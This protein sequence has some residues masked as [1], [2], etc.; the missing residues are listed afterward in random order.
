MIPLVSPRDSYGE[1]RR[2][3]PGLEMFI[4]SK[5]NT[6]RG[7]FANPGLNSKPMMLMFASALKIQ[8][9]WS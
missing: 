1:T 5:K 6:Y 9:G 4:D 7:K 3:F 2:G 8:A